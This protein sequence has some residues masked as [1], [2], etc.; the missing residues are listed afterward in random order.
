[1]ESKNKEYVLGFIF[2]AGRNAV[3]LI[4]KNRPAWQRGFLN[5]LGGAREAGETFVEAMERESVNE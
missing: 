3:Y 5:G 1:M 4:R 2:T